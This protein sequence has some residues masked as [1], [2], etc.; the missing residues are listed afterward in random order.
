MTISPYV[1][2]SGMFDPAKDGPDD[3][4]FEWMRTLRRMSSRSGMMLCMDTLSWH[5]RLTLYDQRTV[6]CVCLEGRVHIIVCR[7]N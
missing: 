7:R 6:L 2:I 3:K 4:Q 5:A 1:G